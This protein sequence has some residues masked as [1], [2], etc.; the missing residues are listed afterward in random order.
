MVVKPLKRRA[1]TS[2]HLSA[3]SNLLQ[4]SRSDAARLFEHG[5]EMLVQTLH[6]DQALLTRVTHLGHEVL[7][8][9]SAPDAPLT[10]IFE[11]PEKGFCPFVIA[12][13]ERPLTIKD[14][15]HEPRWRKSAGHLELGIRSYAGVALM[16]GD[17][18]HGTL[19]VQHH[20]PRVFTRAELALL[21]TLGHLV[22][23][24]LET[25]NIKQELQAAMDA[26]ELS[27]AVVEDS[28][29]VSAR[30]GLP[31]RRYLDIW[32]R[33]SLFMARRRREPMALAL[34]SQ[35][36]VPGTKGKLAA[37]AAHLRGEDLLVE[38]STDQYLLLLPHTGD[39]GADVLLD[40]LRQSLG[41]H[42]TGA[43]LWLPDGKDMT[44]KS[45]LSR[46][47]K[48]FTDANRDSSPR[49]WNHG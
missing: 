21:K 5:L 29:L 20:A 30:S 38:L 18:V 49:V 24:T 8:W 6:I 37:A 45:A 47:A 1:G 16:V 7:W 31:N 32:L 10:G 28:A 4:D 44:M 23:R 33:A 27:S 41:H 36:M 34:W 3:L 13:P 43:A 9:A 26:L 19:C 12:H 2:G 48:A 11:T 22:E 15:A 35:P 39:T 46:V 14:S 42:P 40:R 25:E 17:Q